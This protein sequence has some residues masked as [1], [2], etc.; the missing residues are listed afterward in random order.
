MHGK[1][2]QKRKSFFRQIVNNHILNQGLHFSFVHELK[3]KF[4][5]RIKKIK[6]L[7]DEV[8]GSHVSQSRSSAKG[9]SVC[10]PDVDNSLLTPHFFSFSLYLF[11]FLSFPL[12]IFFP[13][14]FFFFS[15]FLVLSF[16]VFTGLP[17]CSS[18]RRCRLPPF[19]Y[20][21]FL[22]SKLSAAHSPYDVAPFP[23]GLRKSG[24]TVPHTGSNFLEGEDENLQHKAK[25]LINF[26][27]RTSKE[28]L[29]KPE[30]RKM[31][32]RV[33]PE[34]GIKRDRH[35]EIL[36]FH[37]CSRFVFV[38][39]FRYFLRSLFSDDKKTFLTIFAKKAT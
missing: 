13:F 8:T 24:P 4:C 22:F 11:L 12:F 35:L 17:R 30:V 38:F 26:D 2:S 14:L 21:L 37:I 25:R 33:H 20:L 3:T 5:H 1:G 28:T 36:Y 29:K 31:K 9:N 39:Y 16:F 15:L 23:P 7:K 10:S 6:V 32:T 34:N 18:L 19:L 27:Q